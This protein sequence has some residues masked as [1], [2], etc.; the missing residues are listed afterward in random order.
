MYFIALLLYALMARAQPSSMPP[1]TQSTAHPV[2]SSGAAPTLALPWH[3]Y[4]AST[5]SRTSTAEST[6]VRISTLYAGCSPMLMVTHRF[7]NSKMSVLGK[8]QLVACGSAHLPVPHLE[9]PSQLQVEMSG[10]TMSPY[11]IQ[12]RHQDS[13][14]S[15]YLN[16]TSPITTILRTAFF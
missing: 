15:E 1:P 16:W 14:I 10:A 7:G 13:R 3:T 12:P 11:H 8:L 5:V 4:T 9:I 6:T 2:M